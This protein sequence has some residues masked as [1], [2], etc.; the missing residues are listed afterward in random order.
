MN[1]ERRDGMSKKLF[2][3]ITGILICVVAC[4]GLYLSLLS[5]VPSFFHSIT[6]FETE[7]NTTTYDLYD[8]VEYIE[9]NKKI[10]LR[11]T[12]NK[13]RIGTANK[14]KSYWINYEENLSTYSFGKEP[15][16]SNLPTDTMKQIVLTHGTLTQYDY[17]EKYSEDQNTQTVVTIYDK[18][19][20][21]IEV[22][23][24]YFVGE[25]DF[26]NI[27]KQMIEYFKEFEILNESKLK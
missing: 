11:D 8:V 7:F 14:G 20:C 2:I 10:L 26:K 6:D 12:S 9:N 3:V 27:Q 25:Q 24:T 17:T 23:Y 19:Q 4:I 5:P 22:G 1:L 21:Y 16:T 13:L 15:P 18:D